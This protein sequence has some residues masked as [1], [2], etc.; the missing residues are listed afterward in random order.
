LLPFSRRRFWRELAQLLRCWREISAQA[1][2]VALQGRV[3]LN[4]W[5]WLTWQLGQG[6]LPDWHLSLLTV[7]VPAQVLLLLLLLL[8]LRLLQV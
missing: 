1:P 2:R 6:Q 8:L 4:L 7:L 5:W 3:L